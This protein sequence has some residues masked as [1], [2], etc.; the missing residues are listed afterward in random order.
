M[1]NPARC[2]FC[3]S[4]KVSVL[5]EDGYY[6]KCNNCYATGSHEKTETEAINSWSEVA[7]V[8]ELKD[9]LSSAVIAWIKERK[10]GSK[11]I[12][13]KDRL[14]ELTRSIDERSKLVLIY[15]AWWSDYE[16]EE[17]N[18][19]KEYRDIGVGWLRWSAKEKRCF[20]EDAFNPLKH[21]EV[22]THWMPLPE[23][24]EE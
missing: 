6:C 21:R 13:V 2:P 16:D 22:V 15:V 18:N 5:K 11:W 19:Q 8:L 4:D 10:N 3:G 23:P 1:N 9:E 24:P 12:S 17:S 20:W 14:P 7:E